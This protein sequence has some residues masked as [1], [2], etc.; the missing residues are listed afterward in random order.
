VKGLGFEGS[1]F[2][3]GKGA[4]VALYFCELA[5]QNDAMYGMVYCWVRLRQGRITSQDQSFFVITFSD[6]ICGLICMRFK[7]K[8]KF[9]WKYDN[10]FQLFANF[11]ILVETLCLRKKWPEFRYSRTPQS[12]ITA[13]RP[14]ANFHS[15]PH[16][17]VVKKRFP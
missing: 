6:L 9:R 1:S 5:R 12:K 8:A 7:L 2:G 17:R 4:D 15:L 3:F 14:L 11:N 13:P 16:K 10:A